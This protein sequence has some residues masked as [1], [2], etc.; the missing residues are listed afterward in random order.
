MNILLLVCGVVVCATG[1][2]YCDFYVIYYLPMQYGRQR[3]FLVRERVGKDG[4]FA[5]SIRHH[6]RYATGA[7]M[8]VHF[9]VVCFSL[10]GRSCVCSDVV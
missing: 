9:S 2:L 1:E 8:C 10:M 5:I 7:C 3:E 4:Y 6:Y